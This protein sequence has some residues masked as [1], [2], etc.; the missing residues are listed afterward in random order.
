M[1]I[2]CSCNAKTKKNKYTITLGMEYT[3]AT[4]PVFEKGGPTNLLR[5]K[6]KQNI[7]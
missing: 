2:K 5:K 3:H 4:P 1:K 7:V 6:K